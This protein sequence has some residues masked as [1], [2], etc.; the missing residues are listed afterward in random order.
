[1]L[2]SV[3]VYQ[4]EAEVVNS[5]SEEHVRGQLLLFNQKLDLLKDDLIDL[6]LLVVDQ[7]EVT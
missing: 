5:K 7:L 2:V 3:Y 1:V 6:E 4:W